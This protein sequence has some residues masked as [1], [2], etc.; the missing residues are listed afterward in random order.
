MSSHCQANSL[1]LK[2][3][4]LFIPN[5]VELF[6]SN[7]TFFSVFDIPAGLGG[8]IG[9]FSQ[10]RFKTMGQCFT[11]Q[12]LTKPY[13]RRFSPKG[14]HILFPELVTKKWDFL[15]Q[16]TDKLRMI[17]VPSDYPH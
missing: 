16:K 2:D 14:L 12:V 13:L 11:L 17:F 5:A 9:K 15:L 1:L 4:F 8:K 10:K 6:S 3:Y 7:F